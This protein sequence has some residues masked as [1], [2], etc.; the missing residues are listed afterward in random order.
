MSN[1]VGTPS[2]QIDAVLDT[3]RM[4][5]S[6]CYVSMSARHPEG[7]DTDYLEWHCLDHRPEQYR[8]AGLRASLR[9]VSTP[10]C[11]KARAVSS[12]PYDATDHVMNYF[13]ADPGELKGFFDLAVGL[14]DGGRIPYLLPS[15]EMG[16][17]AFQGAAAA[18]RI[19][20]GA[21]VLPWWP[22]QGA[23]L[24]V[25]RGS[26]P[27]TQL[28]E[29]PGVAGALWATSVPIEQAGYDGASYNEG[30]QVSYVYLDADPAETGAQLRPALE[31][32][33]AD[34]GSV[35]LLAAPFHTVSPLDFKRYLP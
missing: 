32:R 28:L 31:R 25:E 3:G 29:E 2:D 34:T 1:I 35:P 6:T 24:L 19:R 12:E 7:R 16:A 33:W 14:K 26:A 5:I 21:D 4:G 20:V 22:A 11:R 13:F 23:Y 10:A 30:V 18:P 8:L 9:L 27:I 17:Y 15:V